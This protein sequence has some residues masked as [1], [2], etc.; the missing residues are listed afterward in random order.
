MKEPQSSME[1]V[2][3][4]GTQFRAS[5]HPCSPINHNFQ[6]AYPLAHTLKIFTNLYG[7]DP[8]ETIFWGSLYRNNSSY[9]KAKL[10]HTLVFS[11]GERT[12]PL[13]TSAVQ[14]SRFQ[15]DQI[16]PG[17]KQLPPAPDQALI[18]AALLSGVGGY[19]QC[20]TA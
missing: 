14:K 7:Y 19:L 11:S 18:C 8:L 13:N 12:D 6:P 9:P 16:W 4:R 3:E 5:P 2:L 10:P 1:F 15:S 17:P 20:D